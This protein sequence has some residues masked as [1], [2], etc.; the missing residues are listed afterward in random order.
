MTEH[1]YSVGVPYACFGIITDE[2]GL[3]TETAPIAKWAIGKYISYVKHYFET[4]KSG[5]VTQVY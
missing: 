1:L 4:K 2:T 5:T 3:I